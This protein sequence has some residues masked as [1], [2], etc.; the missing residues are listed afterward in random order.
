MQSLFPYINRHW[1][2]YT[3]PLTS[4]GSWCSKITAQSSGWHCETPSVSLHREFNILSG[5]HEL[6]DFGVGGVSDLVTVHKQYHVACM[7]SGT[8]SSTAFLYAFHINGILA[9]NFHPITDFIFMDN[10]F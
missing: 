3:I 4:R 8:V 9:G 6:H 2:C 7:E 5:F 10:Q 1:C